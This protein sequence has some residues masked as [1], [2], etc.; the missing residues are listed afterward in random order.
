[1][2]YREW[3][4]H[5]APTWLQ[6]K[7]GGRFLQ[8]IGDELDEIM[9]ELLQA[10]RVS[11]PTEVSGT[12]AAD[13][14]LD[15]LARERV[16]ER[17]PTE[18]AAHL[19]ERI[20]T[21]WDK[22]PT[23]GSHPALLEQLDIAGFDR[24]NLF[25]IQRSGRRSTRTVGG[26]TTIADGPVWTWSAKPP[27]AYAEFGLLFTAAQPSITWDSGAGFSADAAKLNRITW[28][29]RPGKADFLGTVIIASGAAWG[30]PT[31]RTWG[32]FNWGGTGAFIPPR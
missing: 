27:E 4:T 18:T 8:A 6:N 5:L 20:R 15:L 22:L 21:A 23:M 7:W 32:S 30:W 3:L 31:T 29:W 24:A 2:P 19:G 13:A 1:M 26:A 14:A 28:L 11:M 10:R 25:V 9:D 16:L 17:G 12:V